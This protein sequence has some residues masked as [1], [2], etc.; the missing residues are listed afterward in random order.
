MIIS[1]SYTERNACAGSFFQYIQTVEE[2]LLIS[3]IR[4]Q[5]A[6]DSYTSMKL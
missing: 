3:F 5:V 6:K 1:R 4:F 2:T